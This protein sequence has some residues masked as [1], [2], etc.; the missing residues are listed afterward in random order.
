MKS[1]LLAFVAAIVAFSAIPATATVLTLDQG[2]FYSTNYDNGGMSSGRGIGFKA[3]TNFTMSS[4]AIDLSVNSTTAAPSYEF[5][6]FSSVDGHTAGSLLSTDVF[7]LS[8]G[9]GYQDQA[10]SFNFLQNQ[11]YVLNF[12]RVD[13][14]N[15]GNLGTKYSWEDVGTYV[16]YNYGVLTMLEGFAGANPSKGNPL[17]PHMRINSTSTTDVPEPATLALLGLGLLGFAAARSRKQ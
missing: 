3:N 13:G 6:L 9:T 12:R 8:A 11:Y 16:P 15:L 10:F 7:N 2:R 14:A 17:I 1:K 4:L 5:Q